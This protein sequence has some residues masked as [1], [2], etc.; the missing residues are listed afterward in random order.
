ALLEQGRLGGVQVFGLG[1]AEGPAAEA[2]HLAFG[3]ADGEDQ[4]AAEAVVPAARL[5]LDRQAS[6]LDLL[7][8]VALL[9]G[10]VGE[11]VA[12]LVQAE[13]ELKALDHLA[14]DPAALDIVAA[15]L[16]AAKLEQDVV[17]VA[18]SGLV[19]LQQLSP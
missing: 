8:R 7:G 6:G 3:V 11:E 17:E 1:V 13:A 2:D 16:A 9:L 5:A 10:Q 19:D 12:P 14:V 4:P 18:R 15:G